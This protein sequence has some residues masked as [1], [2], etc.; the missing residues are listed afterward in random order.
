MFDDWF[1]FGG[2]VWFGKM[3]VIL[4]LCWVGKVVDWWRLLGGFVWF[5]ERLWGG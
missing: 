5:G 4:L 1:L 2:G 3:L